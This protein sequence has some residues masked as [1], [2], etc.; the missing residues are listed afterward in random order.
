ME[1]DAERIAWL[2]CDTP[3]TSTNVL[4]AAVLRDLAAALTKLAEMRPA[5]VVV[6]SA[7]RNGFIAGADIKEFVNIRTP[8]EGYA[9]VRA[10]QTVLDQ[11]QN[12]PCPTVAALHGFAL[13]GGLELALAC[14]YRIGAD[15]AKLSL[16][17]PEVQLGLHPGF[18]GTVRAV[19]LI[20]AAS[21]VGADAQG[22]AAQGRARARAWPDR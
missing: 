17:L 12:L 6:H 11:L 8:E 7:K 19:R 14:R 18:G 13:G 5:G 4:S 16:G 9:L 2:A 10:G 22:Q 3:G 15:D 20:G 21:G 1:V